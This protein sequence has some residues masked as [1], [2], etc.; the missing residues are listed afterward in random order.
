[1]GT[2]WAQ[3]LAQQ[4]WSPKRHA[5]W[6]PPPPGYRAAWGLC[7]GACRIYIP[8]FVS[9]PISF[10]GGFR[11]PKKNSRKILLTE[12][13]IVL[14]HVGRPVPT[15]ISFRGSRFPHVCS[16]RPPMCAPSKSSS[17]KCGEDGTCGDR[18]RVTALYLLNLRAG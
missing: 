9:L 17:G 8:T 15:S 18:S 10:L 13:P 6:T 12:F 7:Q 5:P 1:M 2:E 16:A 11:F 4:C 3:F 14:S